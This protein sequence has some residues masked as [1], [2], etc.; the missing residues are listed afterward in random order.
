MG[1]MRVSYFLH[2][3]SL[4]CLMVLF[5]VSLKAHGVTFLFLVFISISIPCQE[6]QFTF[7]C[8]PTFCMYLID[9]ELLH[10]LFGH[11]IKTQKEFAFHSPTNIHSIWESLLYG[12]CYSQCQ[13]SSEQRKGITYFL[14]NSL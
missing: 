11:Y 2:I 5:L 14:Q 6:P 1:Q 4:M 9:F 3:S 8:F 7:L 10:I 13:S 12:Q